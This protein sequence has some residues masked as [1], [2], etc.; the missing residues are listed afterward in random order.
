MTE[1]MTINRL[2][3][4]VGL[5]IPS[6]LFGDLTM[7]T[8]GGHLDAWSLLLMTVAVVLV[9]AIGRGLDRKTGIGVIAG[10]LTFVALC[11]HLA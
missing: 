4:L 9:L 5:A 2:N 6:L 11:I 10:Y 3:I 7:H 1:A 8:A